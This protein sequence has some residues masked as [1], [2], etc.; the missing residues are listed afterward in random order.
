MWVK[1]QREN[2]K[3][4]LRPGPGGQKRTNGRAAII[5][6]KQW[7]GS[8]SCQQKSDMIEM[9]L[10]DALGQDGLNGMCRGERGKEEFVLHLLFNQCLLSTV[11]RCVAC[12]IPSLSD[13]QF[14]FCSLRQQW[15]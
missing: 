7:E 14:A 8:N 10:E 6:S 12:L 11:L 5:L 9:F 4:N 2:D 15:L 3:D 13:G 1:C